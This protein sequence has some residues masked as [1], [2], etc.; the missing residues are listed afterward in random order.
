MFDW[1]RRRRAPPTPTRPVPPP[2]PDF[3]DEV[4]GALRWDDDDNGWIVTVT[5]SSERP[6]FTIVVAGDEAPDARLLSHAR[7]LAAAPGP[8]VSRARSLLEDFLTEYPECGDEVLGLHIATVHLPW[9]DRPDD[10]YINFDGPDVDERLWH[11]DYVGRMP[12]DLGF[13]D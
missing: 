2:P 7:E 13:D 10:G 5:G 4:L 1:L 9:P 6:S 12:R 11:C 8:L 3:V